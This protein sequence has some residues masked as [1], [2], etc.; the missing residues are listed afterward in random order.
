[1][2]VPMTSPLSD[3]P[4]GLW[5]KEKLHIISPGDIKQPNELIRYFLRLHHL[6]KSPAD[7]RAFVE[8]IQSEVGLESKSDK[9][10]VDYRSQTAKEHERLCAAYTK[11]RELCYSHSK[12]VISDRFYQASQLLREDAGIREHVLGAFQYLMVDDLHEASPA[13]LTLFYELAKLFPEDSLSIVLDDDVIS[14]P[15]VLGR[16][17]TY[18][19]KCICIS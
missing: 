4:M 5:I 6:N 13:M 2:N 11:Y 12:S 18:P 14:N 15:Y 16:L 3:H 8:S 1:M 7:Y 17:F 10:V 9:F 19:K